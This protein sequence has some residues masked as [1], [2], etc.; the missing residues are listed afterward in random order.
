M[1]SFDIDAAKLAGYSEID[2]ETLTVSTKF[3]D[4][5]EQLDGIE[6]ELGINQCWEADFKE[7]DG[8][9]VEV[10]GHKEV[11]TQTLRN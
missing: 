6:V 10:I 8:N 2:V 1:E 11:L 4:V 9:R 5:D 3:G 7:G